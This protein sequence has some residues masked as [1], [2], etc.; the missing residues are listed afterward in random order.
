[1]D[2][3]KILMKKGAIG[4]AAR[5]M[6]RAYR[7]ERAND[8]ESPDSEIFKRIAK[9]RYAI[10]SQKLT[11]D[12]RIGLENCNS[13]REFVKFI[14]VAERSEDLPFYSYDPITQKPTLRHAVEEVVDEICNEANID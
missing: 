7:K 6:I 1:M 10:C 14:V 3:G 8:T 2:F 11:R 5:L 13:L 12:V 9:W 4:G